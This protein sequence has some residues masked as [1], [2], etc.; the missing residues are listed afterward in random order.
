MRLIYIIGIILILTL[1]TSLAMTQNN[2]S[3]T[4]P[5]AGYDYNFTSLPSGS[6]PA[7]RSW[8]GF[9]TFNVTSP[10]EI[11]V[12]K[13]HGFSGL[14]VSTYG[15][16]GVGSQFLNMSLSQVAT[17]SMRVTFSWNYNNSEFK[18]GNNL[19]VS[20]G[21]REIMG[22]H[23]G[24]LYNKDTYL[25]G[26]NSSSLGPDPVA[27][28]IYTLDIAWMG[29]PQLVYTNIIKGWNATMNISYAIMPDGNFNGNNFSLDFGGSYSNLTVYNIYLDEGKTGFRTA[30][31]SSGVVFNHETVVQDF[32]GINMSSPGW[33]PVVDQ[34]ANSIIYSG[35]ATK[36]GVYA[37]N[38][39]NNTSRGL[40][41]LPLGYSEI[42]SIS[43]GAYAYFLYSNL[44][45]SLILS[46]NLDSMGVHSAPIDAFFGKGTHMLA[47]GGT[48]YIIAKNGTMA[49]F[50]NSGN[51]LA[52]TGFF[53]RDL[54][55]LA[56]SGNLNGTL[57]LSF[58]TNGTSN[59]SIYGLL[60]NGTLHQTG[61][62]S[63]T[64]FDSTVKINTVNDSLPVSTE[65]SGVNEGYNETVIIGG[66]GSRP[67]VLAR[68]YSVIRASG[69]T[70]LLNSGNQVY[71][72]SGSVIYPT[73]MEAGADFSY[74]SGNRSFGVGIYGGS[75]ILYYNGAGPFSDNGIS[76]QFR[77]PSV[78]SGD[79]SLNYSVSSALNYSVRA[80]VGNISLTPSN[81]HLDFSSSRLANGTYSILMRAS[82]TAGYSTS[83]DQTVHVDNFAPSVFLDP[84]N[85]SVVLENSSL[86]INIT[87]LK[88]PVNSTVEFGGFQ[89]AAFQGESFVAYFP[90]TSGSLRM[91]V[92]ITDE[93][94]ITRDY[95]FF[96]ETQ[97]VN[98][99]G[100]HS[101]I[102]PGSFLSSGSLNITWTPVKFIQHYRISVD[103]VAYSHELNTTTNYTH[104][105]LPSGSY[106]MI[107]MALLQNSS[108]I[109]VVNESF[110]V[111]LY[112]P[113]LVFTHT[114]GRFFSFYGDSHN[115]TLNM[116]V[117]SNISA[118]FCLNIYRNNI[119]VWQDSGN[120]T[121]FSISLN[122]T[123]PFI[124]KNG[125]FRVNVSATEGSG[126]ASWKEFNFSVNNSI[127]K[128]P[129]DSNTLNTNITNPS[130]NITP[131]ENE[132][133]A[134]YYGNGTLGGYITNRSSTIDLTRQSSKISLEAMTA[135]GNHNITNLTVLESSAIPEIEAN[136]SSNVLVWNNTIQLTYNI[137]DPVNLSY[138][139]VRLN[140]KTVYNSSS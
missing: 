21:S 90:D 88:G 87:G 32:A 129:I 42:T 103:S 27:A 50:S 120:G 37:Y 71:A 51:G 40:H 131:Q 140:N 84:G 113:G 26:V 78:L 118:S 91:S 75:I 98:I 125:I 16:N 102:S 35:N 106:R 116:A 126:R 62:F 55:I 105:N 15:Y 24:P 127:P 7:N 117:T 56:S 34:A 57:T 52:Q 59:L 28:S 5:T 22:Y 77:T 82:N 30:G 68:K 76:L 3:I 45:A 43:S 54:G 66:N 41:P 81:G 63:N 20:N 53:H 10:S 114:P 110:T 123:Y 69:K 85:G 48:A 18:T 122:S 108:W 44:S 92:N 86:E 58:Y 2:P 136:V 11:S 70:L 29:N 83:V 9:S 46:V 128:I 79:V 100:Y 72:D 23:F 124:E 39:Y 99:S 115:N 1:P 139:T 97:S 25:A 67:Q 134:Y 89:P 119:T 138:L 13:A 112:N 36:P 49:T 8:I 38:Y 64:L 31:S 95:T 101:D 96:Y 17:F 6:F 111:Q 4:Q 74:I 104:V 12:E 137:Q 61:D 93:F 19:E 73:N 47:S 33:V 135:W 14:Q 121:R 60:P 65:T 107:I 80:E 94:G 132:T 130:L 109:P 133:I